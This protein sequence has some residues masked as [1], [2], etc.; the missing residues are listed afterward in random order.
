V[1]VQENKQRVVE[2]AAI[3]RV[4]RQGSAGESIAGMDF[5]S[6]SQHRFE[7]RC[8]FTAVTSTHVKRAVR[9]FERAQAVRDSISRKLCGGSTAVTVADLD[10]SERLLSN[11][12]GGLVKLA[13]DTPMLMR[14]PVIASAAGG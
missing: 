4:R 1:Q 8:F 13:G 14:H 6:S 7:D 11:F 2:Q 5:A 9:D 12:K 3:K 10:A